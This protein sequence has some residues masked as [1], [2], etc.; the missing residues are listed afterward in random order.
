[1]YVN[2]LHYLFFYFYPFENVLACD[3]VLVLYMKLGRQD[4]CIDLLFYLL[5]RGW[6]QMFSYILNILS[7]ACSTKENKD[8]GSIVKQYTEFLERKE[9]TDEVINNLHKKKNNRFGSFY[10]IR[11][12][13]IIRNQVTPQEF[14]VAKYVCEI[15]N[16][17]I[18]IKDPA[19]R[20]A[21]KSLYRMYINLKFF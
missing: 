14:A 6:L 2:I 18:L 11:I 21:S 3:Y 19:T 17:L 13:W 15:S 8:L 10:L 1:M 9:V 16:A 5:Q 4:K 7:A 12:F 20:K